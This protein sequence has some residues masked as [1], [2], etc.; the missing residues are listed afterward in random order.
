[1]HHCMGHL[2]NYSLNKRS[3][4]FEHCSESMEGVFGDENVSSKRPLTVCLRQLAQEY[5]DFDIEAFYND[6]ELIAQRSL[7]LMAPVLLSRSRSAEFLHAG[8][9]C[10]QVFGFDIML[11][12]KYKAFLLEVNNSPSLCVDEALP[13]DPEMVEGKLVTKNREKDKLC[14]CMDMAQAHWHQTSLVD[15]ETKSAMMQGAFQLLEQLQNGTEP[16]VENYLLVPFDHEVWLLL[17]RLEA[18]YSQSGAKSFSSTSLRR[19][20]EPL[21]GEKLQKHDLD[22][23]ANRYRTTSFVG[24]DKAA[25]T[26][27]LRFFDFL[28]LTSRVGE[29]AFGRQICPGSAMLQR[30]V[31]ALENSG[32]FIFDQPNNLGHTHTHNNELRHFSVAMDFDELDELEERQRWAL[33]EI[34]KTRTRQLQVAAQEQYKQWITKPSSV[35]V[36]VTEQ[37]PPVTPPSPNTPESSAPIGLAGFAAFPVRLPPEEPKVADETT[38]PP[39]GPAPTPAL[40]RRGKRGFAQF[41]EMRKEL[42]PTE[43]LQVTEHVSPIQEKAVE[44]PDAAPLHAFAQRL[45]VHVQEERHLE[46]SWEQ[47]QSGQCGLPVMTRSQEV[48]EPDGQE[49]PALNAL[50]AILDEEEKEEQDFE[51]LKLYLPELG[52]KA[53]SSIVAAGKDGS[54]PFVTQAV[55]VF[56]RFYP[57]VNLSSA[58]GD[59]YKEVLHA[60]AHRSARRGHVEH[61]QLK[62]VE[63]AEEERRVQE[64]RRKLLRD[65]RQRRYLLQ[66]RQRALGSLG[67][68]K[69]STQ[70]SHRLP[71]ALAASQELCG[72]SN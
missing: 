13:A 64:E 55:E 40:P 58:F 56:Q 39:A 35:T 65:L 42:P 3:N 17:A 67:D 68:T 43:K 70:A 24:H 29:R 19:I 34:Q 1:M 47:I 52:E 63:K 37:A 69:L 21:C 38:E 49:V 41:Q 46:K 9:Q 45:M 50:I 8:R 53:T 30:L 36:E 12:H 5:P 15:L 61:L 18:I 23:L 14:R 59:H 26:D 48:D 72:A 27:A 2:T 20:Y 16:V 7:A 71:K 4:K 6:V 32:Y 33:K 54:N 51:R 31:T 22:I 11:D 10:F 28:D 62:N 57:D 66:E 60:A 25:N 44:D